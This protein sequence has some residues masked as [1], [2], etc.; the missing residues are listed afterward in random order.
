MNTIEHDMRELRDA[1]SKFQIE[2]ARMTAVID[3][4]QKTL[5]MSAEQRDKALVVQ[6]NEFERILKAQDES[7]KE[8]SKR[9]FDLEKMQTNFKWMVITAGFVTILACAVMVSW[10][11]GQPKKVI[12]PM[13]VI[14]N[15]SPK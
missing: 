3:T 11:A 8:H 1:F 14:K 6:M 7:L 13:D 12:S 9:L 5:M 4:N 2:S 10:Y 15:A